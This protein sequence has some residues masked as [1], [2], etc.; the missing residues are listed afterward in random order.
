MSG[1][2][3]AEKVVEQM[4]ERMVLDGEYEGPDPTN[5]L[6][7]C[8][9]IGSQYLDEARLSDDTPEKH[10]DLLYRFLDDTAALQTTLKGAPPAPP[11]GAPGA[12]SGPADQGAG[13]PPGGAPPGTPPPGAAPPGAPPGLPAPA[14]LAAAA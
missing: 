3:A 14:P 8:L 9:R 10:I 6:A 1:E 5:D 13:A 7:A 2:R 4:C 11:P 12:P